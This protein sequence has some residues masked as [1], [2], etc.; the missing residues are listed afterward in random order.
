MGEP[1]HA[2]VRG[3]G[4]GSLTGEL[5]CVDRLGIVVDPSSRGF[6]LHVGVE[7]SFHLH[8]VPIPNTRGRRRQFQLLGGRLVLSRALSGLL[9]A[10]P[11]PSPLSRGHDADSLGSRLVSLPAQ[12]PLKPAIRRPH[13]LAHSSCLTSA[14]REGSRH[15]GVVRWMFLRSRSILSHSRIGE[16]FRIAY[17]LQILPSPLEVSNS[18]EDQIVRMISPASETVD[19]I[20]PTE[21][22]PGRI[23]RMSF[24]R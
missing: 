7:A 22:L 9:P 1:Y 13:C 17:T 5:Q 14:V 15:L 20:P 18:I 3:S 19:A 2:T 6:G 21:V 24:V 4:G 11:R 16:H 23:G 10:T 8:V 12:R